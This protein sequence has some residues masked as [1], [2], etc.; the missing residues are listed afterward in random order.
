LVGTRRIFNCKNITLQILGGH[1]GLILRH[2]GSVNFTVL[3]KINDVP[4]YSINVM[5]YPLGSHYIDLLKTKLNG[6]LG[7]L[8]LYHLLS[9]IDNLNDYYNNNQVFVQNPIYIIYYFLIITSTRQHSSKRKY[10]Y[11]Y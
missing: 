6:G 4:Y 1:P 9:V 8:K 11:K 2:T 3:F 10:L 5:Q 7:T